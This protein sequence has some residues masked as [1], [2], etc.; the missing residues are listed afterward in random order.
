MNLIDKTYN[1]S[2]ELLLKNSTNQGFVAASKSKMSLDRNYYAIFG[3]DTMICSLAALASGDK[4]LIAVAKRSL[5]TLANNISKYGQIPFAVDKR[6]HINIYRFPQSVDGNLWWLIVFCFYARI[7]GDKKFSLRYRSAREQALNWLSMRQNFGLIEQGEAAD[8]ADEMPR[9]GFVLYTNALWLWLLRLM[10]DPNKNS[11]Y[12][13]FTYFFTAGRT[14]GQNY[15]SLDKFFPNFRKNVKNF[16][17]NKKYFMAAISRV[18]FDVSFDVY[19]N[20]LTGLSGLAEEQKVKTIIAE[21][22][23]IKANYPWPIRV[24]A[25][26]IAKPQQGIFE[27]KHQN[28]PWL[29]HNAGVWPM[30]GGFWVCL[31]VKYGYDKLALAELKRLANVNALHNWEFNEFFH[32]Q[33]GRPMG[34]KHQSWNAATYILAYQA[35]INNKTI[36]INQ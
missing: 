11:I 33:T 14:I 30:V 7:T 16:I 1:K 35:V 26:P 10:D 18:T 9:S 13:S 20:I 17:P 12:N 29:Y 22:V 15:R 34:V 5:M 32:G 36:L 28:K 2:I 3:R 24:L 21:I 8:W 6:R 27:K 4:K 31:L 23:K 25:K 19:G